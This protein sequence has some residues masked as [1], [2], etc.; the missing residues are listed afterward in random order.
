MVL[1][2]GLDCEAL[3]PYHIP[4]FIYLF[5]FCNLPGAFGQSKKIAPDSQLVAMPST[6]SH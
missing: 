6:V 4:E 3:N 5:I 2:D 1:E